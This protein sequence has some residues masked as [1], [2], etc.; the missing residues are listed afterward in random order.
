VNV[1]VLP[2]SPGIFQTVMSDGR[3][4]AVLVR[5]DGSFVSLTNP[6]RRGEQIVAF[7]TGLGPTTQANIGTNS[8]PAPGTT[9]SVQGQVIVGIN[10]SGVQVVSSQ[11][12]PDLIGVYEVTFLVPPD[13]P[14]GNNIVFSVAV[15]PPNSSTTQ[16]SNGSLIPIQ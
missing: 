14:Q 4:R 12:S 1:P 6:A 15:N 3:L 9:A 5:P 16:F 8:V 7:L 13:A 10:N 2:A 11:L